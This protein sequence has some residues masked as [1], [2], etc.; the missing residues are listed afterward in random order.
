MQFD[1]QQDGT[2][3]QLKSTGVDTG[4][5]LERLAAVLQHENNNYDIDIFKELTTAVATLVP[6][7][8]DIKYTDASVRVIADHIRSTAFM[9]VDGITPSNEGRGY[10]LRSCLLYTSPSP[11]DRT[12]SRM[13]SSA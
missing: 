12:R 1:R 3:V 10:V 9:V 11:R 13:P 7:E 6:K 8:K 2:L 4:M 5:G